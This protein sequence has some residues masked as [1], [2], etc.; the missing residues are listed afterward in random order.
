[1][2]TNRFDEDIWIIEK[3]ASGPCFDLYQ[4]FWPEEKSHVLIKA[5]NNSN[6]EN[7]EAIEERLLTEASCLEEFWS[8]YFPKVLDIRRR[9][10]DNLL[11]LIIEFFPGTSLDFYL[12][13][14]ETITE[15]FYLKLYQ[16]LCFALDYL[17]NKKR[18][19]HLDI[20]PDNIIV[21]LE[22]GIHLI[23][24]ENAKVIGTELEAS[25]VRGK[26]EF[27]PPEYKTH[28]IISVQKEADLYG[29]GVV[30]A[31]A[32]DKLSLIHQLK[33]FNHHAIIKSLKNKD[34]SER[35]TKKNSNKNQSKARALI[36]KVLLPI[37]ASILIIVSL[38]SLIP[39]PNES[40][41]GRSPALPK[42]KNKDFSKAPLASDKVQLKQSSMS[43][44][45]KKI[46]V[47]LPI[48]HKVTSVRKPSFA[49]RLDLTMSQKDVEHIECM[50]L[51]LKEDI[52]AVR[53]TISLKASDPRLNKVIV[54]NREDFKET[55]ALCLESIYKSLVLPKH[56]SGK[57][58]VITQ[59]LSIK[60]KLP[61][62]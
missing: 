4:A 38:L 10:S 25:Q 26:E 8:T 49:K 35:I 41:V 43:K 11:Y 37:V 39:D 6:D 61:Q 5:V 51:E 16:D 21:D 40:R 9:K 48:K 60:P 20:S 28:E 29:L 31:K 17:H 15:E 52:P 3:L 27:L 47:P 42:T 56:P 12:K 24:F 34:A 59:T 18:V 53:L 46:S 30:L 19:A 36:S 54:G 62:K 22:G 44:K 14:I 13:G 33:N 45:V 32:F 50:T 7:R 57:D 2:N 55:T 58:V 1:M 23:D